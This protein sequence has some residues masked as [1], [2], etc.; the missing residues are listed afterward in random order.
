MSE[1]M[2]ATG[3][4]SSLHTSGRAARRRVEES[5]ESIAEALGARPSE[6]LFTSGGTESDN[7]AVAG[8][9][10]A[11]GRAD[12]R[13]RRII[14]AAVEHHAVLDVVDFLVAS[15]GARSA[16]WRSTT[17]AG[18]TPTRSP[19]R[20]PRIPPMSRVVTVMWANNEVGTVNPIRELAAVAKGY[21][22]PFHTDAV[23]AL[24]QL[25]RGLRSLRRP[26]R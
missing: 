6:V 3:N 1:A 11:G 21:G 25:P 12:P 4:A 10:R 14:A 13:R 7:L 2:S 18:C 23:Q 24:G 8:I 19:R 16:G 17:S 15:E 22:I 9:F 5:R 20:S 26:T